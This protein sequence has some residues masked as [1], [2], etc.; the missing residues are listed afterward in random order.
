[1]CDEC[2]CEDVKNRCVH[3]TLKHCSCCD[4]VECKDCGVK[5]SRE[6]TERRQVAPTGFH[7]K[8]MYG[9]PSWYDV[10]SS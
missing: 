7:D 4:M 10:F 3:A 2:V 5:W 8:F 6:Y 1:M 9:L